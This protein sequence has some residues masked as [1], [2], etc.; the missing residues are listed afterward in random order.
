MAVIHGVSRVLR[1]PPGDRE[2]DDPADSKSA[3]RLRCSFGG[4]GKVRAARSSVYFSDALRN[5]HLVGRREAMVPQS[6]LL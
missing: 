1:A 3:G 2:M 4:I 6:G 5:D